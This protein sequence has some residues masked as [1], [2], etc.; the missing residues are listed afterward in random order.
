MSNSGYEVKI[1]DDISFYQYI[2]NSIEKVVNSKTTKTYTIEHLSEFNKIEEVIN[3]DNA[4]SFLKENQDLLTKDYLESEIAN[5]LTPLF[6][7]NMPKIQIWKS[8]SEFLINES[9]D[10]EEFKDNTELSIPLR[11]I[12]HIYG[13]C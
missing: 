5:K 10:L 12:F 6:N 3:K 4:V 2:V 9:I 1:N 11:N 7:A 8:S 13:L